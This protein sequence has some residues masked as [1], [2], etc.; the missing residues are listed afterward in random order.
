MCM[1]QFSS[2][3]LIHYLLVHLALF[4][5]VTVAALCQ[6]PAAG[7]IP[8]STQ[9]ASG[10]ESIDLATGNIFVSIPV[11]AKSGKIPFSYTLSMNTGAYWTGYRNQGGAWVD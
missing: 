5:S 6:D 3:R 11:K 2:D 9:A 8:F 1:S 4:L 10:Y 7:I